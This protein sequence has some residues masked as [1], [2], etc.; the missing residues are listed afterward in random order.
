MKLSELLSVLPSCSSSA[1]GDLEVWG[2]S[3]DSRTVGK[4]FLFFARRGA[5]ASGLVFVQDAV[6]KGA[7]VVVSEDDLPES[8]V[9]VVRVPSIA[10]AQSKI[11][12]K[13][14][15]YPSRELALVGV[16]GTNGKTTFT[17]LLEA[18][19]RA[20]GWR[21]GVIGTINYRIPREEGIDPEILSAPNTTPNALELQKLFRL[22]IERK[23]DLAVM[24]VSSHALALGRVSGIEFDGA[25]FTNLTQDHLDFH[26]TM[27]HY[28]QAKARLFQELRP[29]PKTAGRGRKA[30]SKKFSIVNLDDPYGK[31]MGEAS[32]LPAQTYSIDS[33]ADCQAQ[34]VV[35]SPEETRFVL[36][37]P[38]LKI[39]VRMNLLGRHNVYNALA[40]ASAALE[41]GIAP[42]TVVKG[43]E[44]VDCVPGRLEPVKCGQDFSVLVDYAHTEDALKNVLSILRQFAKKRLI[45]VFG[46][47]GDRDRSKRPLMGA[48]AVSMS[49]WVIVTSDNPRTEDPLKI[50]LDIEV[51]IHRTEKS[52]YEVIVDREKAI[53]KALK[54]AKK[55]DIVLLAGKGHE[56][57]QIFSDRTIHFDDREIS[58][59]ILEAE[60]SR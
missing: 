54:M 7:V 38:R 59:K 31:K 11:A 44:S 29:E 15:G 37:T 41:L 48:A 4:N 42:E 60:C 8:P 39:P 9:P 34:E 43:L 49:D 25:V 35:L 55:D 6:S 1:P 5:K 27:E 47:G 33:K 13:F 19:G 16:T 32:A 30:S 40:A 10:E 57:Y 12:E 22:F 3:E 58:R 56:T 18:I 2:I 28:F 51:G 21:V 23:T 26:Q 14:Y 50:T 53:E 45:T 24:E 52:H 46:C 17:Y 20:A 36:A